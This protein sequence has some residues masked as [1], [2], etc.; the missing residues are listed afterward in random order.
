[1][2]HST[3]TPVTLRV[4]LTLSFF[5][6]FGGLFLLDSRTALLN[7][8][9]AMFFLP[10]LVIVLKTAMSEKVSRFFPL[11]A[12]PLY[13]YL[14]WSLLSLGW[15]ETP[16]LSRTIRGSL[17]IITLLGLLIWLWTKHPTVLM[18]SLVDA[19]G[20]VAPILLLVAFSFYSQHPLSAPLYYREA[21]LIFS[22]PMRHPITSTMALIAPV[23]ILFG[24]LLQKPERIAGLWHLVA[25]IILVACIILMQRRT[26]VLALGTGIVALSILSGNRKIL[27]ALAGIVGAAL[28][29]FLLDVNK[30]AS[31][32][33]N[34]RLDIWASYLDMALQRPLIG[35]GLSEETAEI[36]VMRGDQ[37][38]DIAH[39]HNILLT[40]LYFTGFVGTLLFIGAWLAAAAGIL[41]QWKDRKGHMLMVAPLVPGI[42]TMQF[43]GAFPL[44]PFHSN[45]MSLWIP[46]CL[47]LAATTHTSKK[48]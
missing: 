12:L 17:Q 40:N 7:I 3:A 22:L 38:V 13:L 8:L 37:P 46:L 30:F 39:P 19:S 11:L 44:A 4:W 29:L 6:M 14:A 26:G 47:A 23:F 16:N 10:A 25:A 20:L 35:H 43:D 36:V 21:E 5:L 32:G 9:D 31:K 1:M 45:W 2:S 48:E 15:A 34:L 42:V 27:L 41:R 18:K 24:G 28:L 33:R